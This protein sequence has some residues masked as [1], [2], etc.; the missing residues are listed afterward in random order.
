MFIFYVV[1]ACGP[2]DEGR[3]FLKSNG[4]YLQIHMALQPRKF[5]CVLSQIYRQMNAALYW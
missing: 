5:Q 3:M 4:I 1:M 2:E